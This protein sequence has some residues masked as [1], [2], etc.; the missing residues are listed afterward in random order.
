[1]KLLVSIFLNKA[2]NELF[3]MLLFMKA[4][5]LQKDYK[6]KA[7][8]DP[9]TTVGLIG[10][11]YNEVTQSMSN[12]K[13]EL[14]QAKKVLEEKNKK[15]R[16]YDYI[17]AHDLKS[18]IGGIK[19]NLELMERNIENGEKKNTYLNNMKELTK[20]SLGIIDQFL[21]FTITGD[22][23]LHSVSLS[24]I[25]EKLR[26][27]YKAKIEEKEGHWIVDFKEE[28]VLADEILL[29]Q[30]L[31]NIISNSLKYSAYPE[32]KLELKIS[33]F[34]SKN[35]VSILIEDNGVGL[36]NEDIPRLFEKGWRG[37]PS[38]DKEGYGIGLYTVKNVVE[39]MR[40]S[41]ICESKLNVGTKMTI[42]LPASENER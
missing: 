19:T 25:F 3:E 35:K 28:K 17:V 7:P 14:E 2:Q 6:I 18:P 23:G 11:A 31:S 27:K 34:K 15:L 9:I 20:E 8:E 16:E 1:M 26:K 12:Y 10:Y 37:Q 29:E 13:E 5:S 40:G 33:T 21:N 38:K 36:N 4:Q 24:L 41:L 22:I 30:V 42:N 39:N 32:R